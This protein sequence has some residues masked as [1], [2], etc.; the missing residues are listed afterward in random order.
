M[1]EPLEESKVRGKALIFISHDLAVVSRI[2]DV[3]FPESDSPTTPRVS[4]IAAHIWASVYWDSWC[5]ICGMSAGFGLVFDADRGICDMLS[6]EDTPAK[7][8]SH[9]KSSYRS[10][11]EP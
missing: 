5:R 11:H 2:A 6:E 7:A 10:W 3:D 8:N 1:L 9:Y 4:P